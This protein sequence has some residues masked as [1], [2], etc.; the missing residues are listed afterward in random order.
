MKRFLVV[1]RHRSS[2]EEMFSDD[3]DMKIN[4]HAVLVCETID[5]TNFHFAVVKR[6]PTEKRPDGGDR[7]PDTWWLAQSDIAAVYEDTQ[8]NAPAGFSSHT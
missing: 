8:S 1:L 2:A 4:G 6:I 5:A 3:I 7:P